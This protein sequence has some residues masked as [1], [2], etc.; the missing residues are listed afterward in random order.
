MA[1][2]AAGLNTVNAPP[3]KPGLHL[4]KSTDS[5]GTIAASGYFNAATTILRNDDLIIINDDDETG[6]GAA[7]LQ[8][9]SATGAATVTTVRH[10]GRQGVVVA[11][12]TGTVTQTSTVLVAATAT[13]ASTVTDAN[14]INVAARLNAL[15]TSLTDAK[16][17]A[18][19]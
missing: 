11:P 5:L 12:L 14:L 8:V 17:L 4:Y 10:V 15:I 19:S 16:I 18:S 13:Y 9:T 7:I 1:Y 3:G 6:V 2:A